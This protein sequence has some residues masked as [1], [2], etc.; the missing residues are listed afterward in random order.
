MVAN[1]LAT[2]ILKI[3]EVEERMSSQINQMALLLN[4]L[5]ERLVAL[6]KTTGADRRIDTQGRFDFMGGL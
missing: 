4:L 2:L 5:T 1:E 6:E 3:I